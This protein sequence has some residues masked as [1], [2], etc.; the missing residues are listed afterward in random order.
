[1]QLGIICPTS[2]L[3]TYASL[4]NFHLILPHLY[5][6]HPEYVSFYKERIKAGDF[7]LQDNSIFEL[8]QSLSQEQ[9]LDFAESLGVSEMSAPEVLCNSEASL[10]KVEE[11]LSYRQKQASKIPVLAVAQGANI[12][13]FIS[14]FFKLNAIPEISTLGIPFDTD[15][16]D[17]P[18]SIRSK[19]LRYVLGRWAV[20]DIIEHQAEKL[21]VKIKPTH[22]MGLSDGVELQAYKNKPWIR[23]ND[24]SSAFVHGY[25]LVKYL[26]RGLPCEKITEKLNFDLPKDMNSAQHDCILHNINKLKEFIS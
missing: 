20:V 19:T 10:V 25:N 5:D 8:D 23:S 11:F 14:Y 6:K 21:G 13:D 24:S 3:H 1:M 15:F 7:V 4:S 9:L 22:L 12:G 26:D 16:V 18:T 2:Q 17:I